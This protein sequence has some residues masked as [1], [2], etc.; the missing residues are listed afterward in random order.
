MR[1]ELREFWRLAVPLASAQLAQS[2]TGLLD[3]LMMGWLG[4]STLAAGSLATNTF[5]TV[6]VIGI[7]LLMGVS[8]L[9]AAAQGRQDQREVSN[10]SQ[11]SC[12]L[13][14]AVAVP[15]ALLLWILPYGME[16]L[17][18]LPALVAE[19]KVYLDI[20]AL[21]IWPALFFAMFKSVLGA[22]TNPRAVLWIGLG[23]VAVNGLGNYTLGFGKFGA[24]ALGIAGIA[25][26]TAAAHWFMALGS[27]GY[28]LVYR[29]ADRLL[30]WP[31]VPKAQFLRELLR[32]GWPLS[33]TLGLEVGLFTTVTYLMG[34]LGATALAAHQV[35]F[36]TI[37]TIF[38]V[39]LGISLATTVRVGQ[40]FGRQDFQGSR[41][42]A[43]LAIC[44]SGGFMTV[45]SMAMLLWPQLFI[46]LYLDGN[47]PDNQQ[48]IALAVQ[49]LRI[50]A[51]AQVA[52]G[53]QTTVAGAIRGLQDTRAPMVLGF[54]AFWMVGLFWGWFCGFT[55]QWGAQ[56]LWIGQSLGVLTAATLYY[57]RFRYL[58]GKLARQLP[59]TNAPSKL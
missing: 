45:M 42:A 49:L 40:Y 35:V 38:M 52:D 30:A 18:Q 28:V 20:V 41:R 19:S 31:P 5:M 21:G 6:L 34:R 25:I 24:P 16:Q 58:S 2:V 29:R 11:Q 39:P 54:V 26:A 36:Q 59:D 50:A 32:L 43:H 53:I 15:A 7:G 33:I 27:I 51:I 57:G 10:W 12:W 3:T 46:G 44:C 55:L 48:T 37:V 4:T 8:P 22:V 14:L 47:D 13:S 23:G 1:A 56:G 9:I 17:G